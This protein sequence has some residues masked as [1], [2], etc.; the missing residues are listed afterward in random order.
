MKRIQARPHIWGRCCVVGRIT[1]LA[2]APVS[3]VSLQAPGPT[4]TPD[5]YQAHMKAIK[6]NTNQIQNGFLCVRVQAKVK[7]KHYNITLCVVRLKMCVSVYGRN[8]VKDGWKENMKARMQSLK[9]NVN[10]K[11][12]FSSQYT[13][14][15]QQKTFYSTFKK[16][17]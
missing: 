9:T 5:R 10:F 3:E 12:L 13:S 1:L 8:W 2:H 6:S 16:G 14:H 11:P 15:N 17:V 4:I 7:R